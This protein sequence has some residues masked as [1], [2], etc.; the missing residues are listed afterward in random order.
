MGLPRLILPAVLGALAE[1]E[2]G[3][4][5]VCAGHLDEFWRTLLE[6]FDAAGPDEQERF[7]QGL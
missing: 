5:P 6:A 1:K 4:L 2:T 7:K 3:D